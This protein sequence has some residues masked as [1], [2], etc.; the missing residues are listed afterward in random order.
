MT[1]VLHAVTAAQGNVHD[2]ND[3][4]PSGAFTILSS[5]NTISSCITPS[6]IPPNADNAVK[7]SIL[8][9][10]QFLKK[11]KITLSPFLNFFTSVPI[12]SIIPAPSETGIK[13]GIP[14]ILP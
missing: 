10:F 13:G 6:S 3:V 8:P 1:I 7:S 9:E 4:Q 11:G 14:P 2:S 5:L 12:S